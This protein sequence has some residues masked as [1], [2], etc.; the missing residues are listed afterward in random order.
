MEI[1][2]AKKS[3]PSKI[4]KADITSNFKLDEQE[5]PNKGKPLN[6]SLVNGILRMTYYESVLQ[7]SIKANIVY[8]D[9]GNAV[10]GKSAIEGLPIV[11][12]EDFRLEFE[13]NNE[14]KIKVDMNVNTV[15][16]V[17]EDSQK[18]VVSMELVSEEFL[19]N[20][21]GETRLRSR[22]NGKVSE[23]IK[24][25]LEKNLKTEKKLH[26]EDA[27][28]EY[29]FIGNGRKPYYMMN[30]LSKQGIPIDYDKRSAGFLFFETSEGFH[31]KSL[32]GLFNQKQK[33]SY[34]FNN[35]TDIQGTPAGYDGKI[36]KYQSN[37][38]LNV[39]SKMNMGAYKTKIVLFNAYNCEYVTETHSAYDKED[40][41][42]SVGKG[43][44]KFNTKFD[45]ENKNEFT[46]TTLYMVDSGCLPQGVTEDQI[47]ANT[48][49]NFQAVLTLNQSI[50]RYNQLFGGMMEITIA[51][52]F[53][54]HAGDVI[55]VDIFSFKVKKMIQ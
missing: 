33:K 53:S 3:G 10:E 43:L 29:N 21:M 25:I 49:D 6:A 50:R 8:G 35:S 12:T 54:L 17:Y 14:N 16:P 30:L 52:D 15:T 48:A 55:F 47:K 41:I 23:H 22:F 34:I 1:N 32:E 24:Q 46:R 11:G 40:A 18:N 4:T 42:E 26:I 36:L 7:D 5:G 27:L 44:P 28:N 31:F 37:A 19:L 9:V 45:G 20:E 39:Q 51:G 13:D 38:T 2:N